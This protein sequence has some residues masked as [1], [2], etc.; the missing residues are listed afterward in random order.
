M[1]NPIN[2]VSQQ[3]KAHGHSFGS[4]RN[5]YLYRVKAKT[6]FS[7][8]PSKEYSGISDRCKNSCLGKI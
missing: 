3:K 7:M 4:F 5:L 8:Y 2:I 6:I 1:R